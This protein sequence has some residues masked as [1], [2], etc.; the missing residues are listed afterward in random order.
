MLRQASDECGLTIAVYGPETHIT[1][2]VGM[3]LGLTMPEQSS[4]SQMTA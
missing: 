2:I 4:G 1:A 3:A